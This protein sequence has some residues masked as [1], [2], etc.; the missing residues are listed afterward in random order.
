V[1]Q[2]CQRHHL[3]RS[4]FKKI[5]IDS[6][7]TIANE[8]EKF[9]SRI[10]LINILVVQL[11]KPSIMKI[12]LITAS[13]LILAFACTS[14]EASIRI[15]NS[16]SVHPVQDLASDTIYFPT[17]QIYG[18]LAPVN[19]ID[20]RPEDD[21]VTMMHG[22]RVIRVSGC[23]ITSELVESVRINNLKANEDM[24]KLHGENWK[25][26]FEVASGM[27]LTFPN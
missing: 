5:V 23:S 20:G 19:Y 3:N 17:F 9:T 2:N 26:D 4:L 13:I 24:I 25:S 6:I 12:T 14:S 7:V 16:E 8:C 10:E 1:K 11:T 15:D 22:F 21:S 27:R 18:E